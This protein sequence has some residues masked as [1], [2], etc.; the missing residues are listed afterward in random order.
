MNPLT[1][2][3]LQAYLQRLPGR[4][5]GHYEC[6]TASIE[7]AADGGGVLMTSW[8]RMADEA[9]D[10]VEDR[11]DFAGEFENATELALMVRTGWMPEPVEA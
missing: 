11:V 8:D 7:F 10:G 9:M 3:E 5:E 4:V 2:Q 1:V 6:A